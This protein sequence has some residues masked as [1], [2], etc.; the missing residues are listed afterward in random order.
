LN[1]WNRWVTLFQGGIY[2]NRNSALFFIKPDVFFRLAGVTKPGG[3]AEGMI[4]FGEEWLGDDVVFLKR[5][6]NLSV[7]FCSFGKMNGRSDSGY[8]R[9]G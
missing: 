7:R 3:Y 4:L 1:W 6:K 9:Y 5:T 2:D 8:C